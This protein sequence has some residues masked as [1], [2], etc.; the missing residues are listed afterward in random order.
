[1]ELSAFASLVNFTAID[2]ETAH[3]QPWSIC[4]V[5]LV[6][7]EQGVIV[8]E[9]EFLVQPPGNEYHWGNTRVHGIS[10]KTTAAAPLFPEVWPELQPYIAG[11]HVVAHNALFDCTCLRQTL[12]FYRLEPVSFR[13][14]CTVKI[15]KKNL[16]ALCRQYGISLNHHN[17]L[18]DARAC[19]LLFLQ[20]LQHSGHLV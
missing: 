1:M 12:S 18:S 2:F 5:G 10:R 6:V 20:H 9:L 17:A 13:Q 3:G 19:A 16:A 11:K 8:K 4:Q 15:Y 14:H 7:V